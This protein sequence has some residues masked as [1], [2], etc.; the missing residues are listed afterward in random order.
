[1]STHVLHVILQ[2]F[3]V[4]L[5]HASL[6]SLTLAAC[7]SG[8]VSNNGRCWMFPAAT[9][10]YKTMQ[11]PACQGFCAALGGPTARP[12]CVTSAADNAFIVNNA[13]VSV[14]TWIGYTDWAWEGHFTWEGGCSSA[15]TNWDAGEPNNKDNEDFV[16]LKLTNSKWQDV[17]ANRDNYCVC[18]M[19]EPVLQPPICPAGYFLS[20]ENKCYK[21]HPNVMNYGACTSTCAAEN[22]QLLC[23]ANAAQNTGI[24]RLA[25]G[26]T[27]IGLTDYVTEANPNWYNGCT[28]P[29]PLTDDWANQMRDAAPF[30]AEDYY[31]QR[32][33]SDGKWGQQLAT[34]NNYCACEVPAVSPA[35]TSA[36]VPTPTARPTNP[37][38]RPTTFAPSPQPPPFTCPEGD[39]SYFSSSGTYCFKR[40]GVM[41]YEQCYN[42]C[43]ALGTTHGKLTTLPFAGGPAE[44]MYLMAQAGDNPTLPIWT[45]WKWKA[46]P[47]GPYGFVLAWDMPCYTSVQP[48]PTCWAPGEPNYEGQPNANPSSWCTY[49]YGM[50]GAHP[51]QWN[52]APCGT[53]ATCICQTLLSNAQSCSFDFGRRRLLRG[54]G[55]S[56][57]G[58]ATLL[59][60]A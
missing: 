26:N 41:S 54:Q 13:A 16:M 50:G 31:Y 46:D 48:H 37:T 30:L 45:S 44:S 40:A 28:A 49:I 18:D 35:P 11:Y 1:M 9:N 8:W 58:N 57:A 19:P 25:R 10:Y 42:T 2:A 6:F 38:P 59:E 52:D 43:H 14:S 24:Q 27:W 29:R 39:P 17:K 20:T 4:L 3:V 56:G 33:T 47:R 22:S 36:P 53:E 21:F 55:G 7:P 34:A 5:F 12:A 32:S 60:R 51:G 23:I 15:Y